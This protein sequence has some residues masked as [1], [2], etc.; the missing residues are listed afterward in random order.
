MVRQA[1]VLGQRRA[2]L[3]LNAWPGHDQERRRM[4]HSTGMA[5]TA[6]SLVA[7]AMLLVALAISIVADHA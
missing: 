3:G 6:L 7:P 4:T 2:T 1:D 5:R